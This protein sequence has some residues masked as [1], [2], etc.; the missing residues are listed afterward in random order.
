M[1][2]GTFTLFP[3]G[4][5]RAFDT[6]PDSETFPDSGYPNLEKMKFDRVGMIGFGSAYIIDLKRNRIHGGIVR[7]EAPWS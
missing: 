7:I 2:T 5:L 3:L 6:F 4:S 1:K